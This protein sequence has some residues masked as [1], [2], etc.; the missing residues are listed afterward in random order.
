M[1]H[2]LHHVKSILAVGLTLA[3]VA[4]APATAKLGHLG[5]SRLPSAQPKIHLSAAQPT[6]HLCGKVCLDANRDTGVYVTEPPPSSP[7]NLGVAARTVGHDTGFSWGDAGIGAGVATPLLV[8]ALGG[9]AAMTIRRP[10][11]R[12]T[13]AAVAG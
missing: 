4:A 8:L 11:Q 10:R 2:H 3:A 5:L 9:A 6:V 7:S 12:E 13:R 1:R